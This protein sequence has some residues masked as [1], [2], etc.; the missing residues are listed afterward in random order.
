MRNRFYSDVMDKVT[1]KLAKK[2][3][4]DR[5][6]LLD[7]V[8]LASAPTMV[9]GGAAIGGLGALSES[10]L[11]NV[12]D[13]EKNNLDEFSKA[14]SSIDSD[15]ITF[16]RDYSEGGHKLLGSKIK[17]GPSEMLGHEFIKKL[18]G[19]SLGKV[20]T[21]LG[22]QPHTLDDSSMQH[23][24]AF[25]TSPLEARK[26]LL[27]EALGPDAKQNLINLYKK[28]RWHALEEMVNNGGDL[29]QILSERLSKHFD[30][31]DVKNKSNI[32]AAVRDIEKRLKTVDPDNY[33]RYS[34]EILDAIR[35]GDSSRMGELDS[36]KEQLFN[37]GGFVGNN[38]DDFGREVAQ[39][40]RAPFSRLG[41]AASKQTIGP[42]SRGYRK[43][44]DTLKYVDDLK[45]TARA[46]KYL[47][48]GA[49]VGSGLM[50]LYLLRKA[51]NQND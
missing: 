3:D 25:K 50:G 1:V 15:P 18:R 34:T 42:H 9:A 8:G 46:T 12:L 5:F 27:T 4:S 14:L 11:N 38:I 26:Q 41:Q 16:M 45:Q 22:L 47:G 51:M 17:V 7:A 44:Y 40:Q 29:S 39:A 30:A 20:L 28:E 2:D 49:A 23:Y 6:D 10:G 19:G 24:D 32:S 33:A 21:E 36:L 31:N 37:K 43:I 13:I 48:R 35:S